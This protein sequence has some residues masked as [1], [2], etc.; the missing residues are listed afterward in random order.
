MIPLTDTQKYIYEKWTEVHIAAIR[1]DKK[2]FHE[3]ME[4]AKAKRAVKRGRI[5]PASE[6]P[7]GYIW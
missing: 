2:R 6:I 5:I 4:R 7:R 1:Y 3:A